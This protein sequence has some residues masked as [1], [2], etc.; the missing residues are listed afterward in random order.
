MSLKTFSLALTLV[1]VT[2]FITGCAGPG[3]KVD[4]SGLVWPLPPDE[5]RIK[6]VKIISGP[7]DLGI[8]QGSLSESIFGEDV[9]FRFKKPF[10]VAADGKGRIFVSD[11][12]RVIVF[13]EAQKKL[14][15]FGPKS[16]IQLRV[17]LGLAVSSDGTL[18]VTDVALDKVIAFDR[19]GNAVRTYGKEGDLQNPAAVA[20]DEARGR[21]FVVDS[22]KHYVKAYSLSGESLFTIGERGKD[23]GKFNFPTGI[24][25]DREGNI[26]VAD[27]GNFRVQIFDD[28]GNFVRAFGQVG[29]GA[30]SFARL[31]SI[32]LDSEGHIYTT[33]SGFN[34]IQIFDKQGQLLLFFGG[35]GSNPG[36]YSLLQGLTIDNNDKIYAVDQMGYRIQV[37]QYLSEQYKKTNAAAAAPGAK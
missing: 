33:D 7:Q 28:K 15:E 11:I 27:S 37:Y 30:G 19:Q 1:F 2:V 18:Y 3:V 6:F 20:V 23:T 10:G 14:L 21:L 29:T 5:P 12:G 36:Y 25:V 13:D 17:P 24:A 32:A 31:K 34:I 9:E 16:R 26:Y 8:G 4:Y 35:I 22:K